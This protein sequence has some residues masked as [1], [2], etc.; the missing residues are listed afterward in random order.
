MML[1]AALLMAAAQPRPA[2]KLARPD[3]E[4]LTG[5]WIEKDASRSLDRC[6]SWDAVGF[7]ADGVV[8][9]FDWDGRWR[10]EGDR[11]IEEAKD[12]FSPERL[13]SRVVR[14]GPNELRRIGTDGKGVTML[15]CPKPET[16]SAR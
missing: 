14:V 10:L 2:V 5:I 15:R 3:A 6:A 8:S 12:G 1:L 4:W 7:L 16:P 11:L 9:Q 13:E